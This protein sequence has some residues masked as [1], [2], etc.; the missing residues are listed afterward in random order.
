MDDFLVRAA[1]Q[2]AANDL[3]CAIGSLDEALEINSRHPRVRF[4]LGQ[5]HGMLSQWVRPHHQA[6]WCEELSW[7]DCCWTS[8]TECG[9]MEPGWVAQEASAEHFRACVEVEHEP[10]ERLRALKGLGIALTNLRDGHA[11]VLVLREAVALAPLDA[12]VKVS[13]S[14]PF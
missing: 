10:T 1:E 6:P 9:R 2:R 13:T 11:A 4:A 5:L 3:R 14:S 12:Q 8:A 7:L